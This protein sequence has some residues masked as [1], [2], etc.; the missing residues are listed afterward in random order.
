MPNTIVAQATPPGLSGL[1]VIRISGDDAF[2][3]A[4][5]CF[6]GK[7]KIINTQTHT[8]LYG[9]FIYHNIIIDDVTCSIFHKPHSYTGENTVEFGTHGGN[10][11]PQQIINALIN[12]GCKHAE[13]GEFTRRA[14]ING[15]INLIQAEAVADL[16]HSISVPSANI[17]AKQLRGNITK[18]LTD[19]RNTLLDIAATIELNIDFTEENIILTDNENILTNIN[20]AINITSSLV[21]SFSVANILR[22]GFTIAIVGNPNAGKSTLFNALLNSQRAIVSTKPGTTRDYITE[23]IYINNIPVKLIDTAGL[24]DTD[25]IIEI[26]G[27]ELTHKI[28]EEAN[29]ILFINDISNTDNNYISILQQIIIKY[30]NTKTILVNNKIDLVNE[31][32][33]LKS[34]ELVATSIGIS[35]LFISANKQDANLKTLRDKISE[36]TIEQIKTSND[37]LLN[38]RQYFKLIEVSNSL[39]AARDLLLH[40]SNEELLSIELRNA[41]HLLG[42]LTGQTWSEAVLNNIFERFCIGK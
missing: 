12:A 2:I 27:I 5:K 7:K 14:F 18:Q 33:L 36:I 32:I 37:I 19:L 31:Q 35:S 25:D 39:I 6:Q 34:K 8:I 23:M 3:I 13:A 16:I 22:D 40:N 41:G 17:S 26:A 38:E 20:S 11:I 24:R 42:E 4:D 9:D 30:P 10:I 1:S 28:L 21:N 15:K 29:L